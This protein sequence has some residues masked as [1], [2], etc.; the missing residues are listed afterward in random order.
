MHSGSILSRDTKRSLVDEA[1][2]AVRRCLRS[3]SEAGALYFVV[4]RGNV[5]AN[6]SDLHIARVWIHNI[7]R[8]ELYAL[9]LDPGYT[10]LLESKHAWKADIIRL[11]GGSM[12]VPSSN[13]R[14]APASRIAVSSVSWSVMLLRIHETHR[15]SLALAT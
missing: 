9:S 15:T 3:G 4:G 11:Y 6:C 12:S 1:A 14:I 2:L 10:F 8:P 7:A 5:L 13:H